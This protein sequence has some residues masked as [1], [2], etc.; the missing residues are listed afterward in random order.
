MAEVIRTPP[1]N[2][3][4][5]EIWVYL[6]EDDIEVANSTI[7]AIGRKCLDCAELPGMGRRRDDLAPGLRCISQ[8]NYLIF[9]RLSDNGIQIMRVLHGARDLPSQFD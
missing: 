5:L 4:L 9:Y 8:G 6:A 1:A 3:D 7:Q 2:A